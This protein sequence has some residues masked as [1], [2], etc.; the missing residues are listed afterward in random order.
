MSPPRHP[1]ELFEGNLVRG[2]RI[3]RWL[4]AGDGAFVFLVERGGRRYALKMSTRPASPVDADEVEVWRRREV[5]ALEYLEHPQLLP[6]LE[7]GRWPEAETGYAY[8][9]TPSVCGSTFHAWRQQK[10]ASLERC[11]GVLCEVLK[12]LESLHER[13]VCHRNLRAENLL[14]RWEDDRPFLIDFGPVS[15]PWARSLTEGASHPASSM[16]ARPAVDLYAFGVLLYETLTHCRPFG[17]QPPFP[18]TLEPRA[19][20]ALSELAMRL[21][22]KEPQNRPPSARAVRLELQRIRREEGHAWVWRC[23]ARRPGAR[24][25][26]PGVEPLGAVK[27]ELP[28]PD[29]PR[30]P[31]AP[32]PAQR[33]PSRSSRRVE[34]WTRCLAAVAVA[35]GLLGMGWMLHRVVHPPHREDYICAEPTAP[36]APA[37]HSAKRIP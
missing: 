34:G 5:A 13:G 11:V 17:A 24:E 33:A 22:E 25:L 10:R 30:L 16:E 1:N 36:L 14:V 15:P 8:F 18:R 23:L 2:F 29:P 32:A 19:P 20:A 28:V 3:V 7:W 6:V 4:G 9:V 12:V 21:L 35:L 27:E 26:P 31:V 37:A